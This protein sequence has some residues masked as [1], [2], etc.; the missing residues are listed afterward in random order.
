M[1]NDEK[2][3]YKLTWS[4]GY[5]EVY[6]LKL[7]QNKYWKNYINLANEFGGNY[8]HRWGDF[9][10]INLFVRT[11]FENPIKDLNLVKKNILNP[12]IQ[13]SDEFIY[14]KSLDSYNSKLF[15]FLIK[16]KKIIYR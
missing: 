9:Q 13:G 15:K 11:F 3:I 14:Y 6:N 5:L 7:I 10:L 2:E 1:K 4:C 8:K 16:L 12:K